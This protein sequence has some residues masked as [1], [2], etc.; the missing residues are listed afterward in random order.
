[1]TQTHHCRKRISFMITNIL[2]VF[3]NETLLVSILAGSGDL[4]V[5]RAPLD[6]DGV[7]KSIKTKPVCIY[8]PRVSDIR[9]QYRNQESSG[10]CREMRLP[11]G[12]C[13]YFSSESALSSSLSSSSLATLLKSHSEAK[14]LKIELRVI[15]EFDPNNQILDAQW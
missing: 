14:L 6:R 15:A 10:A 8:D 1:M 2:Q 12:Y 11:G 3:K 9:V 4:R 5:A 13:Y 7:F